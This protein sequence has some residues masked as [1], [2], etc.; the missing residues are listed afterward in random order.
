MFLSF[1]LSAYFQQGLTV[2]SGVILDD[3]L[4]QWRAEI[5][6]F[7]KCLEF[8]RPLNRYVWSCGPRQ[9]RLNIMKHNGGMLLPCVCRFSGILKHLLWLC[10][11]SLPLYWS[12]KPV[13]YIS[14]NKRLTTK[15]TGFCW[16][17]MFVGA[18]WTWYVTVYSQWS[19]SNSQIQTFGNVAICWG[20][21]TINHL[22]H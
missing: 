15:L 9:S 7:S 13:I 20:S 4:K 5:I 16:I 1:C 12:N 22:E 17:C 8:V 14:L 6:C 19:K 3:L 11:Y 18:F 2:W 21:K 10:L